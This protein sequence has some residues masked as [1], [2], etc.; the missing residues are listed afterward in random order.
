MT[1][2]H[3][4]LVLAILAMTTTTSILPMRKVSE[5]VIGKEAFA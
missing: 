5:D 4:G 3:R 2:S 1:P